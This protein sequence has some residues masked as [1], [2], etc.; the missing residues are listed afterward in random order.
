MRANTI[1][2]HHAFA[3]QGHSAGAQLAA[4]TVLLDVVRFIR[5]NDKQL[6]QAKRTENG[7]RDNGNADSSPEAL[8][9]IE[10]LILYVTASL[11]CQH[12]ACQFDEVNHFCY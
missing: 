9:R 4:Q 5:A 3:I 1:I 8:P 6:Q 12:H 10:G 7:L 11:L 2:L